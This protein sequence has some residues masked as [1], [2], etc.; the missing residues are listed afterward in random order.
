M[1]FKSAKIFSYKVLVENCS[2]RGAATE[3]RRLTN[4]VLQWGTVSRSWFDERSKRIAWYECS[5][6]QRYSSCLSVRDQKQNVDSLNWILERTVNRSKW[7]SCCEE[8]MCWL[9][10]SQTILAAR[11][12]TRCNLL[13]FLSV[14]P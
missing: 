12:C 9:P 8:D 14:I 4:T 3:N 13:R 11:F 5:V 7:W 1:L 6:S 2:T 10:V